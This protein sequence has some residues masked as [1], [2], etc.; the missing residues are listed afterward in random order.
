MPINEFECKAHAPFEAVRPMATFADPCDCPA[1]GAA[2]PRV[3]LTAPRLGS[4]DQG[5]VAAHAVNEKAADSPGKLLSHGPGCSCCSGGAK[6]QGGKTLRRV[7]GAKSSPS[8][9]PWMISH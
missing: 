2:S 1:C 3:L 4:R 5:R 9:R 8:S 7:D 6:K